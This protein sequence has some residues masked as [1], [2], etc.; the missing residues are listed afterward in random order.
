MF[1]EIGLSLFDNGYQCVPAR[2]KVIHLNNW[3]LMGESEQTRSLIE[4]MA[5]S[6]S[7]NSPGSVAYV[8]G[9]H[10]SLCAIDCDVLDLERSREVYRR[11]K[12][13]LGG[14]PLVRIGRKPK[15]A[16]FYRKRGTVQNRKIER[17][18]V[19]GS[20]GAALNLFGIHP[21]TGKPYDWP[22]KSPLDLVASSAEIPAIGEE[23]IQAF[24]DSLGDVLSFSA[25]TIQGSLSAG[26]TEE[27]RGKHG[28]EFGKVIMKQLSQMEPGNRHEI[29]ISV[30]GSLVARGMGDEE[31]KAV[32]EIP[33]VRRFKGDRTNRPKKI[34]N[35][36]LT[37]RRKQAKS[38]TGGKKECRTAKT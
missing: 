22:F 12:K 33:Y 8:F 35:A 14:T 28:H 36:I 10:N 38:L 29:L 27:R 4:R 11:A 3:P 31:I 24:M 34:L 21:D 19:F 2:G 13:I 15:F 26:F 32:L 17:L 5:S 20:K 9:N 16:L 25:S 37:A 6:E 7:V 18:E 1:R 23:E 30:V